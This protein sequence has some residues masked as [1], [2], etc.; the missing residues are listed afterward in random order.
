MTTASL[1]TY[2][3][4]QTHDLHQEL[5]QGIGSFDNAERYRVYLRG[6]G[7][8][9]AVVEPA[10]RRAGA[11]ETFAGFKP[12]F[13]YH[14]AVADMQDLDIEPVEHPCKIDAEIAPASILGAMYVIEGSTLGARLLYK[15]AQDLGFRAD[16]GARHLHAQTSTDRSWSK[17][18][19][20][21]DASDEKDWRAAASSAK[22][23]FTIAIQTFKAART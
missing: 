14:H 23:M 8:F 2:L 3:R 15:R 11:S 22:T 20:L 17:L 5:D 21:L 16:W 9:R 7:A 6:V 13:I 19:S 12:T 1:R 4:R 10:M 18:Q